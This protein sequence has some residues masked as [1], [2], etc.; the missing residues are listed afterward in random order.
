MVKIAV[1]TINNE[2]II[3][4]ISNNQTKMVIISVITIIFKTIVK[5]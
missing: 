5:K 1:S 4:T 3:E 2:V